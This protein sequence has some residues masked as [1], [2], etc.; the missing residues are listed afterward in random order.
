[1]SVKTRKLSPIGIEIIGADIQML[2]E[3]EQVASQVLDLLEANGVLLFR[4]LGLDDEQLVLFA[5]R[6]GPTL[7]KTTKGWDPTFP[8]LF[9]ISMDP[10]AIAGAYMKSTF[11][12]HIDGT[13][14]EIPQ[15]ASLL[16]ARVLPDSRSDTQFAS[17]Y[18]AY[19]QLSDGEKARF[20][21]L[22]VWHDLEATHRRFD[23]DPSPE[24]LE[25]LQAQPAVLQPLVWTHRSGRKS[26]VIGTPASRIEGVPEADGVAILADLLERAT[27]P[28]LVYSHDWGLGDLVIWDNRGVLHRALPYGEDSGREMKRVTLVGNEPIQ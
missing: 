4:G 5:R 17:T 11:E 24:M 7:T 3:A 16:T 18:A 9:T 13:S 12:W 22:K 10:E 19:E 28:A 15:K 25:R 21:G 14:L 6:L 2:L 8:E 26:L 23:P 1:M 27:E 20:D